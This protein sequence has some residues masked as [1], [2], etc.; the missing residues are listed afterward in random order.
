[1]KQMVHR[2]KLGRRRNSSHVGT[3]KKHIQ[4]NIKRIMDKDGSFVYVG[5]G[6][7]AQIEDMIPV[8]CKTTDGG[9]VIIWV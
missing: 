9:E 7:L 4:K 6:L 8:K 2:K 1:M 5:R 3:K